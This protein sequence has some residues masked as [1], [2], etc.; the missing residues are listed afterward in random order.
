MTCL[1][2]GYVHHNVRQTADPDSR[3]IEKMSSGEAGKDPAKA[4]DEFRITVGDISSATALK[5]SVAAARIECVTCPPSLVVKCCNR[6]MLLRSR[7]RVPLNVAVRNA[8]GET[9]A[10]AE[11]RSG[12]L[13]PTDLLCRAREVVVTTM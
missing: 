5:L 11:F 3:T 12:H 6:A 7:G 13:L 4:G 9:I 2:R 1:Y 8:D 10:S